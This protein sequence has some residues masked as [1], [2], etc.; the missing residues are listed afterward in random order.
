M[1][2]T[3]LT[4]VSEFDSI[5]K[6][7]VAVVPTNRPVQRKDNPDVVYKNEMWVPERGKEERDQERK[8]AR[9]HEGEKERKDAGEA[10]ASHAQLE[11]P[12]FHLP[13]VSSTYSHLP[14]HSLS[15]LVSYKWKAVV[16]EIIQ[17]NK[18]GRPILVGTTSVE[19][20]EILSEMLQQQGIKF[21]VCGRS[22]SVEG[23]GEE[24]GGWHKT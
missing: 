8:R 18:T 14:P 13:H 6:L 22:G 17:M 5:Y 4:E 23:G 9:E 15:L 16:A 1:T 24:G 3:A 20:S 11:D 7:P 10:S 21:Q 19:K 2:G 12:A